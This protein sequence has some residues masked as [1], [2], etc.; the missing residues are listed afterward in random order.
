MKS[1]STPA[2]AVTF[3]FVFSMLLTVHGAPRD[4]S[5]TTVNDADPGSE[6]VLAALAA[7]SSGDFG[8]RRELL[9]RAIKDEDSIAARSHVGL[10][11]DRQ[12]S[13]KTIS[14]SM[15]DARNKDKLNKYLKLRSSLQA[16]SV[17][18]HWR[19]AQWCLGKRMTNQARA[20][21]ERIIDLEP[22]QALARNLL[23]Y[24]RYGYDW[25]S[26]QA[27]AE[28]AR[29]TARK[30]QSMR[31]YGRQI[32]KL[33]A[34]MHSPR[35]NVRELA[36]RQLLD[37]QR[38]DATGAVETVFGSKS[39]PYARLA[40]DW[41]GQIDTVDTSLVLA[42]YAVQHPDEGVR[43]YATEHLADRPLYDFVPTMLNSMSSPISML[44]DP[45]FD[46]R[47][48]LVGYRHAFAREDFE[49]IE[50]LTFNRNFRRRGAR[51][52][53]TR[54]DDFSQAFVRRQSEA[55]V[56]ERSALWMQQ[57]QQIVRHNE[58]V[59]QVF[60]RI[61]GEPYTDDP[62]E[63]WKWW[64][65]YNETEYQNYKPQR[66]QNEDRTTAI[67][68]PPSLGAVGECFVAGTP[69]VTATGMRKIEEITTGDLV[70]SRDIVSGRLGWKP[71][72]RPTNRPA[73]PIIEI[74][75]D[76]ESFCC[77]KGHLFWISGRGWKKAS[78]LQVGDVLHGAEEP[79]QVT[80]VAIGSDEVTHNLEVADDANYF[81]G[82]R[83]VLTHDVTPRQPNR[84][85]FP[86]QDLLADW[87]SAVGKASASLSP[88]NRSRTWNE[89]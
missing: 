8:T 64:D 70:L 19:L 42:R 5:G 89:R 4:D 73:A 29:Q 3:G 69:V 62:T 26:P 28:F 6:L 18:D 51:L 20:H 25:I 39:E 24:R 54:M 55:E 78:E 1:L 44:I 21:L 14:E 30:R 17:N 35:R 48:D 23:G 38:P 85:Q 27:I 15:N 2:I 13:W 52:V 88:R 81:V 22:D 33:S 87:E 80:S 36:I 45:Y 50:F 71:V 58:R 74:S 59:A 67:P 61:S 34:R 66:Y 75:I 79:S 86:G 77:S 7:E 46:S 82:H 84:R 53:E 83:M 68:R 56:R 40:I 12:M 16:D 57:N 72:L 65:R 41:M 11:R 31:D 49:G 37:L 10:L 76:G 32:S 43:H 47:G 60:A 63:M 9:V